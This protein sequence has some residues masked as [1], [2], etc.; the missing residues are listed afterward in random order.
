M[1]KASALVRQSHAVLNIAAAA[2]TA[3]SSSVHSIQSAAKKILSDQHDSLSSIASSASTAASSGFFSHQAGSSVSQASSP[4]SD[5][6][7]P[8][9]TIPASFFQSSSPFLHPGKAGSAGASSD[10]L[11]IEPFSITS[12][13]ALRDK[14]LRCLKESQRG[15]AKELW[16]AYL[17]LYRAPTVDAP[18]ISTTTVNLLP[19]L[20]P[21]HHR[22]VLKIIVPEHKTEIA[23]ERARERMRQAAAEAVPLVPYRSSSARPARRQHLQTIQLPRQVRAAAERAPFVLEQMQLASQFWRTADDDG[24]ANAYPATKDYNSVLY[25]LSDT[26]HVIP[27]SKVWCSMLAGSESGVGPSP[28]AKSYAIIV[29]GLYI[30]LQ[31]QLQQARL[32]FAKSKKAPAIRL[33]ELEDATFGDTSV[34]PSSDAEGDER[35]DSLF[36]TLASQARDDSLFSALVSQARDEWRRV[37]AHQ[38]P[39]AQATSLAI[40]RLKSI[41]ERLGPEQGSAHR[42]QLY[43]RRQMVDYALRIMRLGGDLRGIAH[44]VRREYGIRLGHPDVMYES[45]VPPQKLTVHTLNSVILAIGE[46]GTARDMVVAYETL[47]KPLGFAASSESAPATNA[48]VGRPG[49]WQTIADDEED[50]DLLGLTSGATA[51]TEAQ[52]SQTDAGLFKLD[53]SALSFRQDTRVAAGTSTGAEGSDA[54]E[55]IWSDELDS[56][57]PENLRSLYAVPPTTTTF[58]TLIWHLCSKPRPV[59]G[60]YAALTRTPI[61]RGEW[62]PDDLASTLTPAQTGSHRAE[63]KEDGE[64][65]AKGDYFVLAL[66]YLREGVDVYRISVDQ[67]ARSLA[68]NHN[69]ASRTVLEAPY[70]MPRAVLFKPMITVLKRRRRIYHLRRVRDLVQDSIALMDRD[71]EVLR[72]ATERWMTFLQAIR[73]QDQSSASESGDAASWY[74]DHSPE[75]RQRKAVVQELLNALARQS[76]LIAKER[77]GLIELLH[78]SS[79]EGDADGASVEVEVDTEWRRKR[80]RNQG[81]QGSEGPTAMEAG[82]LNGVISSFSRRRVVRRRAKAAEHQE[83]AE[84]EKE[85]WRVAREVEQERQQKRLAR[86]SHGESGPHAAQRPSGGEGGA[87]SSSQPG[88]TPEADAR[89]QSEKK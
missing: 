74:E 82:G 14:L 36:S 32:E 26:G 61:P 17:A 64:R 63:L 89:S 79:A 70:C 86:R 35:D 3:S 69:E 76:R 48:S 71:T 58:R 41:L 33:Q 59:Y 68:Q 13:V 65:R 52:A 20:E 30:H 78:G 72:E 49:K 54:D 38:E 56:Q 8:P 80:P 10:V 31:H 24:D 12:Q 62:D 6:S 9:R 4:P 46:H 39:V 7:R 22:A 15:G 81:G 47:T 83:R 28:N 2:S 16:S 18:A 88:L 11:E 19:F 40:M 44:L 87:S 25:M 29:R 67:L 1:P 53:W 60:S 23:L 42:V 27:L 55:N 50:E 84:A 73:E 77:A 21:K 37:H 75:T 66:S 57:A 45:D 34:P 51:K 5:T 43:W 85:M